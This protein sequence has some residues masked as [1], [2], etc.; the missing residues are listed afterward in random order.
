MSALTS[1]PLYAYS[2]PAAWL[3]L[4]APAFQK[5]SLLVASMK[6]DNVAPRSN[7]AKYLAS[8]KVDPALKAKVER[9]DGAHANGL[10]SFPLWGIAVLFG[11]YAGIDQSMLNKAA[12]VYV[13]SR[14]AFNYLYAVQ[15]TE[16]LGRMRSL[17]WAV[18]VGASHFLFIT[19][20]LKLHSK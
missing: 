1:L 3:L 9:L 14:L 5:R 2:L 11:A 19:G 16:F 17:V 15:T 12:M 4:M 20:A 10:E 6:L 13:T 8:D 7:T 18:G